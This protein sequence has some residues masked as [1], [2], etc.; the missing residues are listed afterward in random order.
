MAIAKK[1]MC[2]NQGCRG[3]IPR[4]IIRTDFAY[5]ALL[6]RRP[7]LEAAGQG[8]TFIELGRGKLRAELV[9]VPDLVT[10]QSIADFLDRETARID[11]LIEKKERF[12]ALADERWRA[13]LDAVILGRATGGKRSLT[14]GQ[15]YISDV[16]ADWVLTP[17]KHL[18]D[19]RRPVMYGI[20]L[21]GPNVEN[22]VMIVKGGDVKPDPLSS[23]RLCK[24]TR[25]IEAGYVRSRLRGGDLVMAIRGYWRR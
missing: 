8:T 20:V 21:P 24:T 17:L 3:L 2:F 5:W 25:E 19:P 10:Q 11:Q 16:P 22:G 4:R 6:A 1:A 13:T 18:V 15:P 9:P 23:D 7:Q 12:S 14:S